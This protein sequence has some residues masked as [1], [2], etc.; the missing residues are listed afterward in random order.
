MR[1]ASSKMIRSAWPA[2]RPRLHPTHRDSS[3]ASRVGRSRAALSAWSSSP[4][5]HSSQNVG[6]ATQQALGQPRRRWLALAAHYQRRRRVYK[7]IKF[8][9]ERRILRR[10]VRRRRDS[11][12][13]RCPVVLIDIFAARRRR[14][15]REPRP[16]RDRGFNFPSHAVSRLPHGTTMCRYRHRSLINTLASDPIAPRQQFAD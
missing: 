13:R 5:L 7:F 10:R 2:R 12:A 4:R 11:L 6:A 15:W 16:P 1:T 9:P 8:T 3:R 14:H